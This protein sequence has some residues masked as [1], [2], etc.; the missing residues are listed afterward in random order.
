MT[1]LARQRLLVAG[2]ARWLRHAQGAWPTVFETHISWV[3][4]TSRQAFK[5]KKA[6]RL[7][8]LD[9]RAGAERARC[10][11]AEL[12][13][14]RRYAPW[15]YLRVVP[16]T[17]SVAA[18]RLG[19]GGRV[20]EYAVAMRTFEQGA[21]WSA[22]LAAGSLTGGEVTSLA[23]VLAAFHARA[24]VAPP[25]S[26]WGTAAQV[27]ARTLADL[28]ELRALL[29]A[30]SDAL[31][32]LAAWHAHA[33][34]GLRRLCAWRRAGAA[35]RECHG[36]LHCGNIVTL[37]GVAVPFDGIEF[38]PALRW[39]DTMQDMAFA[40]MDLHCHGRA[41]L[42]S[43]LLSAYLAA[44]GDYAGLAL[45]TYYTVQRALVRA[46]VAALRGD[47]ALAARYLRC[48]GAWSGRRQPALLATTGLSGSGKSTVC[49]AL[50]PALG[51]IVLRA[52]VERKRLVRQAG[53]ARPG[54]APAETRQT[55]ARLRRVARHALRAG[56]PVLVD[57]ACLQGWQRT[58]FVT[59]AARLQVP[60]LLLAVTAPPEELARRLRRRA[61]M[62]N[63]PS[64][65]DETVLARQLAD[66]QPLAAA[67]LAQAL[68]V[69][70]AVPCLPAVLERL[71][72]WYP[73]AAGPAVPAT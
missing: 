8:F 29:P 58:L 65:A 25:G 10:C 47:T 7:P 20:L 26:A 57:A 40:W 33:A 30:E 22:R 66:A 52:D 16:V 32:A 13:L 50:A 71:A 61:M 5:I 12:R 31:A 3:I 23:N 19:G 51:A 14:N 46:K 17:G 64:D 27:A 39:I 15:L 43:T 72:P 24:A 4:V 9:W 41:D 1:R 67:E 35:V 18:P 11:R 70:S 36:D 44:S 55:Y 63:D 2:L 69:D 34:R 56:V 53:G 38:A 59:L 62:G 42:A 73:H 60:F 6:V 28:D 54:Y 68:P 37:R 48:A 21:L 49:A 45:L